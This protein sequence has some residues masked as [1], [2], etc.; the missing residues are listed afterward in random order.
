[1]AQFARDSHAV[2]RDYLRQWSSDGKTVDAYR[3]LV[4]AERYPMWERRSIR[5]LA[6]YRDLYTSVR[7]GVE[8]DEVERWLSAEIEAPAADALDKVARDAPLTSGELRSM[9]R[10]L[11]ALDRRTPAAYF[12]S[13]ARWDEHMPA[14][15]GQVTKSTARKL[16]RL[17][18]RGVVPSA[19]APPPRRSTLPVRVRFESKP[20]GDGGLMH[21]GLT[22]GRE[23]W[24]HELRAT[25]EEDVSVLHQHQWVILH[26]PPSV[27]WFTSDHPVVRLNYHTE[28]RYDFRGGWGS[29]G[30]DIFLP[31]TP[32]HLLHTQVGKRDLR[33]GVARLEVATQLQRITA[34]HAHE[35]VI[36]HRPIQRATWLRR[37]VVDRA[38]FVH[39]EA[40]WQA[41]HAAQAAAEQPDNG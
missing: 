10:Y 24:L 40:E 36:A 7:D 1:M 5:S 34:E 14:L 17:A 28:E 39:Q 29:K 13:M 11:A 33:D 2:P 20:D 6:R 3:L 22:L 38:R 41:W 31:L 12:E 30:T 9:V 4:P 8:S 27:E 19:P 16:E 26:A 35:W 25:L 37:R 18:R 21:V 23:L 32:R 15:L